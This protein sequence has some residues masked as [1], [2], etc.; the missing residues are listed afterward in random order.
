ML[1][2][3]FLLEIFTFLPGCFGYAE[4]QVDKKAMV[5]VSKFLSHRWDNK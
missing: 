1:K 5:I 3:P 4:N 2:A